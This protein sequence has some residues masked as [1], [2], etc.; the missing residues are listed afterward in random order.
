MDKRPHGPL[1]SQSDSRV[2]VTGVYYINSRFSQ[3]KTN[4]MFNR[5]CITVQL[6][7]FHFTVI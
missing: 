5:A 6:A 4:E 7:R 1:G 3:R 2:S